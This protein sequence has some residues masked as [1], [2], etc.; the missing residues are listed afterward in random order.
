[1]NQ[2]EQTSAQP[3]ATGTTTITDTAAAKVAASAARS[4]VGVHSLGVG[5]NRAMGALRGAVGAGD[6]AQGVTA[7]VG[8][9]EVAVDI[10][11]T[12]EHGRPLQQIA[13]EV[14]AAVYTAVEALTGLQVIEVNIEIADVRSAEVAGPAAA[15][16]AVPEMPSRAPTTGSGSSDDPDTPERLEQP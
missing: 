15:G 13:E 4:V 7:E 16:P 12:A 8:Q 2:P 9:A 6:V 14:R 1:M 3:A 11:L 5:S 10:T